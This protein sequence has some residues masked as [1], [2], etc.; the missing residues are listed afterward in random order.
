MRIKYLSALLF[1]ALLFASTGT[2]TSCKDY[3]DDIA[4]L[5]DQ[6]TPLSDRLT[7]VESSI[8]AL[9]QADATLTSQISAAQDAAEQAALQAQQ[10]AVQEAAAQLAEVREELVGLI[11]GTASAEDV[12]AI[13]TEIATIKGQNETLSAMNNDIAA[14]RDAD[15]QL[16]T[17]IADLDSKV[18]ANATA[19][20]N[21]EAALQTQSDALTAYQGE[22]DAEVAAVKS[23]IQALQE[24]VAELAGS[25][26]LGTLQEQID[27]IKEES[28]AISARLDNMDDVVNMLFYAWYE[29]ITGVSLVISDAT[30]SYSSQ[31]MQQVPALNEDG[32]YKTDDQGNIVYE[33]VWQT[34]TTEE[35]KYNA[36]NLELLSAEA[37]ADNTFGEELKDNNLFS[38]IAGAPLTFKAGERTQ[39]EASFLM[40]VYPTTAVPSKDDIKLINSVGED[41]VSTG[42][43]EVVKVEKNTEVLTRAAANTGLWKVTL[44]VG[45][46]YSDQ[47]FDSMTTRVDGNRIEYPLFAV[48]IEDTRAGVEGQAVRSV[49]SEYNL[50][51]ANNAKAAKDYLDFTVNNESVYSIYN[52]ATRNIEAPQSNPDLP[53]EYIWTSGAQAQPI[54]E[55]GLQNV[56]EGDNRSYNNYLEVT[57]GDAIT[58]ELTPSMLESVVAYYVVMDKNCAVSS[59]ESEIRAWNSIESSIE[60]INKMYYTNTKDEDGNGEGKVT[61]RFTEDVNDIIGF[62]VYAVNANGTLVDPDGRSFYVKVGKSAQA[63]ASANATVVPFISIPSSAKVEAN[64]TNLNAVKNLLDANK[65]YH[66]EYTI[67]DVFKYDQNDLQGDDTS[68]GN[69]FTWQLMN[70]NTT[71]VSGTDMWAAD[72]ARADNDFTGAQFANVSKIKLTLNSLA[73]W[74][75]YTDDKTY[76][77]KLTIK[78]ENNNAV[79]TIDL[80]FAKQ[81][82]TADQLPT[83]FQWKANQIN[84][85]VYACYLD[86]STW[87]SYAPADEGSRKMDQIFTF[88][89]K[90]VTYESDKY[91]IT[92]ST[93][94]GILNENTIKESASI[95]DESITIDEKNIDNTT[96]YD[97]VVAY[98]YGKISSVNPNT[99]F[100]AQ[101]EYKVTYNCYYDS[102]YTWALDTKVWDGKIPYGENFTLYTGDKKDVYTHIDQA[103]KGTSAYDGLFNAY[104]HDVT[105]YADDDVAVHI[106]SAKVISNATGNADYFDVEIRKDNNNV[107]HHITG[108]TLKANISNPTADVASTLVIT[109]VDMYGHENVINIPVTVTKR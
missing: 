19:I 95:G 41:L 33:W 9:Q 85:G 90:D 101:K 34:S 56:Q 81:L 13:N 24:K 6:V 28:Q 53:T 18:A 5:Q 106:K 51:F 52:R 44:K 12:A 103:I 100:I 16:S 67:D 104:L 92:F 64:I 8:T 55:G 61:I 30:N 3:D 43:V 17:A 25:E 21:L 20:G 40:R 48:A 31:Y 65:N 2:F 54:W 46:E 76:T 78:D 22:N 66:I 73:E 98:N 74:I 11:N 4:G 86:P 26:D 71:I 29:G 32:S 39:L 35:S 63:T 96:Q 69:A 14:L 59:D 80:T 102:Q 84:E 82:P 68:W 23:D 89:T 38:P 70:G 49:V 45:A 93:K 99:D 10:N 58:I 36:G 83:G 94:D 75:D 60:G 91:I 7:S 109:T 108:F 77:G 50:T 79:A 88:G 107:C 15:T 1:G 47:I 105:P 37:I 97:A 42:Q 87:D 62:R 27:A 57:S 72:N